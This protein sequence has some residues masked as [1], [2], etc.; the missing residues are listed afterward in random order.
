MTDEELGREIAAKLKIEP[1]RIM[2]D[3]GHPCWEW[4]A[5][6]LALPI[7]S[8]LVGRNG[9]GVHSN[10]PTA[11]DAY[12]GLGKAV[13][14]CREACGYDELQA[15]YEYL[16]RSEKGLVESFKAANQR[17]VKV[18]LE[19]NSL[20]EQNDLQSNAQRKDT[21]VEDKCMKLE[22]LALGYKITAEALLEK[23]IKL[24]NEKIT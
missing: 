19:H 8:C 13:I 3:A 4:R 23:C 16:K 5:I 21:L 20:L 12:V 10:W 22:D 24:T 18:K 1:H 14:T 2:S 9:F 7:A 15:A 6:S 11:N 17:Y